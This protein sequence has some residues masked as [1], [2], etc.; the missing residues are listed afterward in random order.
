[1]KYYRVEPRDLFNEA[2]LLNCL[3]LLSV[4]ILDGEV[5]QECN[6]RMEEDTDGSPYNIQLHEAGYLYLANRT[7][8]CGQLILFLCTTYNSRERYPLILLNNDVE[9][10][11]FT[12]DGEFTSKFK[13]VLE[14]LTRIHAKAKAV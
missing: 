10:R 9:I 13:N 7:F 11:V 1:M 5:P 8:Y 14:N 4:K 6:L 3:G 12:E 2:K